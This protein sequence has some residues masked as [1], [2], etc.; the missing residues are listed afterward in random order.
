MVSLSAICEIKGVGKVLPPAAEAT[1][2]SGKATQRRPFPWAL[3]P[4]YQE[5]RRRA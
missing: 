1:D 4:Q 5:R 3:A 2:G